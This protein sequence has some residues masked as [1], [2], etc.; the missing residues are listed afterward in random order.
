MK[1]IDKFKKIENDLYGIIIYIAESDIFQW[2]YDGLA[3]PNIYNDE[4]LYDIYYMDFDFI[5]NF[6]DE[7]KIESNISEP[8]IENNTIMFEM[9]IE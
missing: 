7:Y 3:N 6:L 1:I 9:M 2:S 4:Q 5:I 8:V